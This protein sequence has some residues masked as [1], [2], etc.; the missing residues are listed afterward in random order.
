V[1]IHTMFSHNFVSTIQSTL[2]FYVSL[3]VWLCPDYQMHAGSDDNDGEMEQIEQVEQLRAKWQKTGNAKAR[4][5]QSSNKEISE[6]IANSMSWI[7]K[8]TKESHQFSL[9][10]YYFHLSL[11]LASL[12][13]IYRILMH[14]FPRSVILCTQPF[15]MCTLGF[16]QPDCCLSTRYVICLCVDYCRK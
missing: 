3:Q 4:I 7:K 13:A 9:F 5:K 14:W 12:D 16:L 8:R 11:S 1:T 10:Y 15:L 2:K 6:K